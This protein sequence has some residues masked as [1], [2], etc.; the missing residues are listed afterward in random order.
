MSPTDAWQVTITHEGLHAYRVIRGSSKEEVELKARLQQQAWN[1]RWT[2]I[3]AA[4]AARLERLAKTQ[5]WEKLVDVER[6]AKSEALDLTKQAEAQLEE[7]RNLLRN[8]LDKKRF[9][10][11]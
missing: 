2:R 4:N 1:D 9:L 11:W 5:R 10:D 6:R 8:A 3:Q 7:L